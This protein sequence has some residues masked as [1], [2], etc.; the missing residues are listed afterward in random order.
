MRTA[1][2]SFHNEILRIHHGIKV[3]ENDD[4]TELRLFSNVERSVALKIGAERLRFVMRPA[5]EQ[6]AEQL[7]LATVSFAL[8]AEGE[9]C[10]SPEVDTYEQSLL[11]IDTIDDICT[12]RNTGEY[13]LSSH[14]DERLPH[15]SVSTRYGL[16]HYGLVICRPGETC[17]VRFTTGHLVR[18]ELGNDGIFTRVPCDP[19][20]KLL[21][22]G[23]V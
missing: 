6:V 16:S 14:Y 21:L 7:Y 19:C 13:A 20:D 1:T 8:S 23:R 18:I 9:L 15:G 4:A 11:F 22:D 12:Q 17:L 3:R 5:D 2:I 10:F